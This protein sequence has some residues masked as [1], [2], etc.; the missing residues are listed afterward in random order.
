MAADWS[1]LPKDLLKLISKKLD[2]E[3]YQLRFRSVCSSWRSSI[4]PKNHNHHLNLPSKFQF[5]SES[6]NSNNNASTFPL[7]KRTI[8]LVT[9]SPSQLQ[10]LNPW[11]I[12]IGPDS[13]GCSCLWNPLS[14]DKQLP[15]RSP[16]LIDFNQL[17]VLVLGQEFVI[18][19]FHSESYNSISMKKVVVCDTLLNGNHGSIL[20][21][22][23]I[24]GKLAVFRSG[25]EQWT[26]IPE[27]PTPYSDVCVFN[28]R[29]IAVDST[30]RT[31]AVGQDL[32]LDLVAEAVFGG[33]TKILV[34]S[35]GELLLVVKY[36][37]CVTQQ[38]CDYDADGIYQVGLYSVARF[39]VFRLDE[40]EKKW[41]ELT[42]LG[43]KVLFLGKDCAF[44]V[45]ASDLCMQKGNYVIFLND[46]DRNIFLTGL[47]INVFCM[48][49]C[50]DSPLFNFPC[51]SKLFWPPPEWVG[52][53]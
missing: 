20:L 47:G 1:Q 44:S 11:L 2:S 10:T 29:P 8:F 41:V 24:S 42:N 48:D 53:R 22:I 27:M 16:Q 13:R 50:Q 40:K 12:K 37:S 35:D 21:T 43:D 5:P 30:G 18:G 3:F 4:A 14:H 32:S 52:L 31:V 15:I 33:D 49:K 45:S 25:D 46:V 28:G 9:P 23:H 51:W 38:T 26:I 36:L 34:E 19:D 6:N 39:V 17:S 7:S